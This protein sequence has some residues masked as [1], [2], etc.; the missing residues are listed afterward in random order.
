MMRPASA[1]SVCRIVYGVE[2][3]P[4]GELLAWLIWV[5]PISLASGPARFSLL[6][7]GY[8]RLEFLA[9]SLGVVTTIGLCLVL[10]PEF[11][12]RGAAVAMLASAAIVW[13][14][15]HLGFTRNVAKLP[16]IGALGR[17]AL[18]LG[19]SW[20][21]VRAVDLESP[22]SA[23]VV[24]SAAFLVAGGMLELSF[25]RALARRSSDRDRA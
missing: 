21:V 7:S 12:I 11:G 10:V 13:A 5:L 24:A 25:L 3:G 18:G 15:S 17:P 6:A 1:R 9:Q 14:T 19:V 23:S 2:F 4:S 20:A 16:S 22:W 8:Q